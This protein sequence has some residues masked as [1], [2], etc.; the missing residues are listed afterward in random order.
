MWL[1]YSPAG[2]LRWSPLVLAPVAILGAAGLVD[3]QRQVP[4]AFRERQS[5]WFRAET[6]MLSSVFDPE[7]FDPIFV[8]LA[9]TP[10]FQESM[11][12]WLRAEGYSVF[13]SEEAGLPGTELAAAFEIASQGECTGF[14]DTIRP[15]PDSNGLRVYGWAWDTGSA[16]AAR[17]IVLADERGIIVG[18][19]QGGVLERPDVH[20]NVIEVTDVRTGWE[21]H[22]AAPP[23]EV[24]AFAVLGDRACPL[25]R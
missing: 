15:V 9:I 6:A 10:E 1:V 8:P 5:G 14:L 7:A 19:G 13:A 2:L 3:A 25:S 23:D 12:G 18:I 17:T 24:R 22:A 4:D 20:A 11:I 16:A 21:G